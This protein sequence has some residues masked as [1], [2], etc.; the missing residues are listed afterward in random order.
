MKGIIEQTAEI[1]YPPLRRQSQA[2]RKLA[3]GLE[4]AEQLWRET[5]EFDH[6]LVLELQPENWNRKAREG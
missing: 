3:M 2:T 4:K 5:A 1:I 6:Q